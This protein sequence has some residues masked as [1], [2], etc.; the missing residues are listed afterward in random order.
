MQTIGLGGSDLISSRLAYGCWRIARAGDEATN[1]ATARR[2]ILAAVDAG[3]TFFDHADI[4]CDGR[5]EAAFGKVLKETPQLRERLI[6]ATKC[7]IRLAGDPVRGPYR[8][9]SSAEHIVRSVDA[10]LR[11]LCVE[12]ID[13]FQLHRPD[14]LM[15]TSE[16]AQAFTE[17]QRAGKVRAFGLSNFRPSQVALLQAACATP[18]LVNQIEISLLQLAAFEDGTLDQCQAQALTPLAW[19]PLGAGLL[20]NGAVDLLPAQQAYRPAKIVAA[21]NA[22]AGERGT[23][24][25]ALALAWLLAH[26]SGIVP[27]IGSTDPVRIRAAAAATEV[28]LTREDWYQLLTIARGQALP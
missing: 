11:R 26:P 12:Q 9:D 2:A 16:V 4:Y 6:V 25:T 21:L 18:L 5:A 19:S 17:V 13:L 7:G 28:H 23:T 3:Y 10:S 22:M 27:I 14:W 8:Y 1:E 20:A 15:N 24:R